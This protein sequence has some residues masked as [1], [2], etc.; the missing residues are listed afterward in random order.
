MRVMVE[1]KNEGKIKYIGLS[2]PSAAS[3]RRA[4]AIHPIA[5]VQNEYSPFC[6]EVETKTLETARELGV[7]IVAFSPLGRGILTGAIRGVE[8]V[9]GEGDM[10]HTSGLPWFQEDNLKK[11]VELADRIG[12]LAKKKGVT[13]AQLTLAWVLAQGD[14]FFAIPGTKSAE[15]LRENLGALDVEVEEEEEKEIRKLADEVA[16]ARVME[17]HSQANYADTPLEE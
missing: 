4:Y 14:D 10:R 3:L 12:A 17:A 2:E 8:D 15:R 1:L 16:G 13:V 6:L 9:R 7:A 5:C 11:N